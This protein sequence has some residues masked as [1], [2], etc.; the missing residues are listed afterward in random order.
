MRAMGKFWRWFRFV[1]IGLVLGL[2]AFAALNGLPQNILDEVQN[3]SKL[4]AGSYKLVHV[5]SATG[6][7]LN[8]DSG[9]AVSDPQAE[10]GTAWSAVVGKTQIG[11][12][13]IY[14][15]YVEL[16]GGD[17]V[18]FYRLKALQNAYG[19]TVARLDASVNYAQQTL[20]AKSLTN[21]ELPVDRYVE[22][23]LA[24]HSDGGKLELRVNWTGYVTLNVDRISLFRLTGAVLTSANQA[25]AP[26][27]VLTPTPSHLTYHPNPWPISDIFPR[28]NPPASHLITFD[29]TKLTPDWQ[30][31]LL[32][33]Q[34]LVNRK[35]PRIYYFTNSMDPFWLQWME[36]N[37]WI[38]GS[39]PA[40]SPDQLLREFRSDYRGGIIT[41]PA[42]PPSANVATMLA[43]VDDALVV[44]PRLE[45]ILKLPVIADLR[46]RWKTNV[47]AYRWAFD[48]LWSRLTHH[49]IA[50]SA[51][52]QL[53]LRD[54]LVENRVFIF[55]LSGQIDG[56]A[57]YANPQAEVNLMTQLFAKMPADIPVM[58]YPYAGPN[59]GIGEGPGVTLFAQFGKYLVGSTSCSNLS[60]HS[61]IRIAQFHQRTVPPPP[62]KNRVYVTWIM[63]DGD[64]LPVLSDFNFPQ[65]W[66][67]PL[68]GSYPIGWTMSPSAY[69]LIPDIADYY[70]HT[71]TPNDQILGAVSGIGYTYPD[72][73]GERYKKGDRE[74]V[75]DTFLDQTGY[76]LQKLGEKAIWIMGITHNSL[77]RQ[78]AERIPFLE[79]IFP[80]YGRN[81]S[82]YQLATYPTA[83][84]VPVFHA[85]T[86]W[87]ENQTPAQQVAS[88]V[89]QIKAFTPPQRPAFLHLFIWNWGASLPVFQQ[90]L[91]ELGPGYVAVRPDQLGALYR[92][93]LSHQRFI[94]QAPPRVVGVQGHSIRF[95]CKLINVMSKSATFT[96]SGSGS[97]E[98]LNIT[99]RHVTLRPS[100]S[101]NMTFGGVPSHGSLK[102]E[103]A[104]PS[105]RRSYTVPVS[106]INFAGLSK[107]IAPHT[108]L[109]FA[110]AYNAVDLAHRIGEAVPDADTAS[111]EAWVANASNAHSLSPQNEYI[112]YGPY[113]G[114]PAGRYLVVYRLKRIGPGS[115]PVVTLDTCVGGGIPITASRTI[116]SSQ[117]PEGKYVRF[118]LITNHP[119]GQ[120]ETRVQWIGNAPV[121]VDDI[122]LWRLI[123][124]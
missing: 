121:A 8:H 39:K 26:Q 70:F 41:D 27:P 60:V 88:L 22:V 64:N 42:M 119:G 52:N 72:W 100:Q 80:D 11:S 48:H 17:Y 35:Q 78:Y 123:H 110:A 86:S 33:L 29:L 76:Y 99:P 5:W 85:V 59:V 114:L 81:V 23:P 101:V 49:V 19:E 62:L 15:P 18:A 30:L 118:G 67:D 36:K 63:S 103:V 77:I 79:A 94:F 58:S 44:S 116:D 1:L 9:E 124:H 61:G 16:P 2:P 93:Y 53:Y 69:M 57:P 38:H 115:G 74:K 13:I 4:P 111:G 98:G 10:S 107:K 28:S 122:M 40:A 21:K 7:T 50:C 6:S 120:I 82:D 55:W 73:F 92:E 46:G 65:L 108:L 112:I 83:G 106:T 20:T 113:A 51:P 25:L 87:Q 96:A 47:E 37:G 104:G 109:Q 12:E 34:G 56:A 71:A 105:V 43:G 102:I 32:S 3:Q 54:Y 91:K 66:K 84:N 90:V 31:C 117:L 45:K 89:Q 68:R 97:L 95:Q 75:F 24:F 14:G